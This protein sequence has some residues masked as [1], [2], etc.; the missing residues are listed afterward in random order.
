METIIINIEDKEQSKTVKAVL[1]KIKPMR[2]FP[3][4]KK[5]GIS[6]T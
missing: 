1:E 4:P 6:C 3:L 5:T 2:C